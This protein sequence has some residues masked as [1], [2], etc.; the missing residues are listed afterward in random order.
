MPIAG[1]RRMGVSAF[2]EAGV[3]CGGLQRTIASIE[4]IRYVEWV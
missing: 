3:N 1:V 4:S 2:R